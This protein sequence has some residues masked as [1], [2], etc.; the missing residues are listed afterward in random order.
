M[1]RL[2]SPEGRS[3]AFDHR[4][5]SGYGRGEGAAV[6][7]L[8]PLRKAIE[9]GD[10]IRAIIKASGMNQDGKTAGITMP[11]GSAQAELIRSV[12]DRHGLNP[13]DTDYVEAHGTGDDLRYFLKVSQTF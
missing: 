10:T 1:L 7:I 2:L 13:L 3:Y 9:D 6:I 11:N 4:A 5:T 12:Y 8:K